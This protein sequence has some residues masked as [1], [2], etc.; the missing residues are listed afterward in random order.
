M[1]VLVIE[2]D[3]RVAQLLKRGLEENGYDCDLAYDGATGKKLALYG[4]YDIVIADVILPEIQGLELCREIKQRRPGLPVIM[5]TALGTTDDKVDGFDAG[6]DDYMVK[7]FEMRELLARVRAHVQR[8]ASHQSGLVL[9]R[10]HD[11]E[12]N[13]QTREVKRNNTPIELTPK[14]FGLLEYMLRNPNRV[15]SRSEIADKV[16]NTRFDTGTNFIDVYINYLRKKVDK[17]FN[18]RL[19]HTKPGV[20]FILRTEKES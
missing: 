8:F 13:L 2:D 20:G 7:P 5:L 6:A 17:P 19:I 10:F 9:L 18:E 1:Q 15:L 4:S 12:M 16:W 3:A 11:L 14:E